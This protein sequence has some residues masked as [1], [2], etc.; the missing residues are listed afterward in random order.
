MKLPDELSDKELCYRYTPEQGC[1]DEMWSQENQ[2]RPHWEYFAAS[3][4]A[5]G[6]SELERRQLEAERL[7]RENGVTYNVYGDPEGLNRPWELDP[8]PLLISSE[9]WAG[10][11]SALIQRAELLNLIL[12][13]LYGPRELIKKGLIPMELVYSHRGFLRPCDKIKLPGEHQLITYAADLA[14]GPDGSMWVLGDRTQAPS[15]AGYALENRM[16]MGRILPSLFR[17]CHVHRLALFFRALRAGL[18]AIAPHNKEDPTVVVM[19]PGPR[20]ET[21]FEHAYLAAYLGYTLVQGADLTVRDERVWLKSLDGLQPVDIILRRVDDNFCDPLELREDSQL[22]VPGLLQAAR[23]GNVSIVN[24]LGS[25]VLENPGLLAFLPRLSKYLLGQELRMPSVATWWCGHP[26]E[27]EYVLNNIDKLVIKPIYRHPASLP[28]FGSSLSKKEIETL[29]ARIK[30]HPHV[31][32]GQELISISTAPSLVGKHLEPRHAVLRSF[33]VAREGD[34]SVM[35]GGLTRTAR[36]N[37]KYLVSNQAGGISKDT[38]VLASEPEKQFSL[39]VHTRGEQIVAGR[40]SLPSRAVENLYWVGRYVERAE[41]TTRL[42]RTVLQKYNETREFDDASSIACLHALLRALTHLTATYPG[43][44]ETG[45]EQRLDKPIDE[46]LNIIFDAGRVGSMVLTLRNMT[47]AAYA[48]R[49]LWSS[50]TWRVIDDIEQAWSGASAAPTTGLNQLQDLLDQLIISLAAFAGFTEESMTREQ[51]W[52]FLDIGRR[53]ERAQMLSSILRS[54][55]VPRF[56]ENT[57]YQLLEAL[58]TTN[59]S[60]ITYRRRYRAYLEQ[61]AIL[62]LLLLDDTNPRSLVY[63]TDRLQKHIDGLPREKVYGR[64]SEEQRLILEASSQLRLSD[65]ATLIP[66]DDAVSINQELD[67]RLARFTN[68]LSRVS[69]E[70]TKTYFSHIEGPQQLTPTQLE[71]DI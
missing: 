26:K 11:E 38:W 63:Q 49:D 17:D 58:L 56:D 22:G 3:L 40:S 62:D 27:R 31:Y 28:V 66:A 29:K 59:E 65:T 9:E 25:S 1:F 19:T 69:D 52:V 21:Y 12:A 54:T 33:L 53:L 47:Q 55:V 48:V 57:E 45:A 42:L 61:Q 51:G 15:G 23:C 32:M 6:G 8:I 39:W 36:D 50:D 2:L 16:A 71:A 24:P 20:N 41:A 34:Y 35:P 67:Q 14:R 30:A 60:L 5:L 46:L 13:D 70:L 44:V 18:A 7:L 4:R 68:L 37:G 10:I 43:F 64:L